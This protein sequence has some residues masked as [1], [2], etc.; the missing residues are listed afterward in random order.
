MYK[1]SKNKQISN[2]RSKLRK[3]NN[4]NKKIE[5]YEISG[6]FKGKSKNDNKMDL[7][8]IEIDVND[9]DD[10]N[11]SEDSH[12]ED[13]MDLDIMSGGGKM[14]VINENLSNL[15]DA[16]KR[17][18][19]IIDD[20]VKKINIF[21]SSIKSFITSKKTVIHDNSK[22]EFILAIKKINNTIIMINISLNNSNL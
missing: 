10:L 3:L 8:D 15:K 16:L 9:L 12:G 19:I 20:T 2:G 7:D 17:D 22:N 4:N 14:D 11:D 6:G 18:P 21:F 13:D 5:N 1:R